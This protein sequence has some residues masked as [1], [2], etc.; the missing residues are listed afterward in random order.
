MEFEQDWFR[1]YFIRRI[2]IKKKHFYSFR[3]FSGKSR[4]CHILG[5]WMYNKPTKCDEN[6]KPTKCDENRWSHSWENEILNFFLMWTTLNFEGRSKTKKWAKNICKGTLGIECEREWSVGLG[7]TLGD[8]QKIKNY[9]SSL[10]DFFPRKADS[11]IL[12]GFEC[13]PTINPQN[14][15]KIVGAIFEKFKIFNFFLC[16]LP[17][18]LGLGWKL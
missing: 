1:R 10:R 17:L 15:I 4:E 11:V 13:R 14:L 5:V 6:R 16:E 9:F 3:D 18:I 7:A 12:L 8:V 2:E